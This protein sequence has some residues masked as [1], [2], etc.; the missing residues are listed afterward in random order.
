MTLKGAEACEMLQ[1]R[2]SSY[3]D[4]AAVDVTL[5]SVGF[6]HLNGEITSVKRHRQ[7]PHLPVTVNPWSDAPNPTVMIFLLSP[8]S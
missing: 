8:E 7:T 5:I 2:T 4:G 6:I 3:I 1:T